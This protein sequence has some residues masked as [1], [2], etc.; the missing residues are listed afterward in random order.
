MPELISLAPPLDNNY[1]MCFEAINSLDTNGNPKPVFAHTGEHGK[2]LPLHA[3]CFRY[4]RQVV[5]LIRGLNPFKIQCPSMCGEDVDVSSLFTRTE[6]IKIQAIQ[7][8]AFWIKHRKTAALTAQTALAG[9]AVGLGAT[10]A[11]IGIMARL[12]VVGAG[13]GVIGEGVIGEGVI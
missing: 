1:G 11:T 13:E 4:S 12:G 7:L 6:R 2:K 10:L 3:D 5:A 9:V 8:K